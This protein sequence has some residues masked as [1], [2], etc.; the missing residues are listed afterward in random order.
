MAVTL[1]R[2]YSGYP[3]GQVVELTANEEAALIAQGLAATALATAITTGAVTCNRTSGVVAFAAG[4]A[5]LVIT[6]PLINANSSVFAVVS[7]AAADGTL[8]RI[9]R[10]VCGAGLVTLYGTANAT[11][12][13]FVDWSIVGAPGMSNQISVS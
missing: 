11:A 1:L 4:T 8:L 13:T 9:E 6:N 5:S 2:S 10:I 12:T 7:Q 3:S